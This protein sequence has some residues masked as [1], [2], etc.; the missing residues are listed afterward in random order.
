MASSTRREKRKATLLVLHAV[1]QKKALSAA[2]DGHEMELC[3]A[4]IAKEHSGFVHVGSTAVR[5]VI[6]W[7]AVTEQPQTECE[8]SAA[9]CVFAIRNRCK[10]FFLGAVCTGT[11]LLPCARGLTILAD[12]WLEQ[13]LTADLLRLAEH[14]PGSAGGAGIF[15]LDLATARGVTRFE[16]DLSDIFCRDFGGKSMLAMTDPTEIANAKR[17]VPIFSLVRLLTDAER[18][19]REITNKILMEEEEIAEMQ[20]SEDRKRARQRKNSGGTGSSGE[21]NDDD[22]F[23]QNPSKLL[24][25]SK[26]AAGSKSPGVGG[27]LTSEQRLIPPEEIHGRTYESKT[28][29]AARLL[30]D[31]SWNKL[32][33]LLSGN[34]D[35][36]GHHGR[37]EAEGDVLGVLHGL[38]EWKLQQK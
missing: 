27:S 3:V 30:A 8:D 21:N 17:F 37:I 24:R 23:F 1:N 15:L 4:D 14:F 20:E 33:S 22:E 36:N 7:N 9:R 18:E 5:T 6:S 13:K 32:A 26:A 31:H 34:D 35:G 25:L 28:V 19:D 11:M 16:M 12:A 10:N 29:R 38:T 2:S